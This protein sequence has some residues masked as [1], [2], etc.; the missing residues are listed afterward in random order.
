VPEGVAVQIKGNR[1]TGQMLT[2]TELL[3]DAY[4]VRDFQIQ[5]APD[6]AKPGTG[7][8][9]YDLA[10]IAADTTTPTLPQVRLML[11]AL[12]AD[13]FQLKLHHETK[14]LAVYNLTI[15]KGGMK[16]IDASGSEPPKLPANIPPGVTFMRSGLPMLMRLISTRVERPVL[17]ETGLSGTYVYAWSNP[18]SAG[19]PSIFT[20]LQD[21]LGLK[22]EPARAQIDM[23]TIERVEKPS[24]N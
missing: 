6:W 5:G 10:A 24:E 3:A 15:A 14:E 18:D 2:L 21:E 1:V 22:L 20:L 4:D 7:S 23:L 17:D 8:E 9:Y 13:R 11:Q 19:D 16:L 12:L